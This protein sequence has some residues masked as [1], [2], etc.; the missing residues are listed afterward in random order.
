MSIITKLS[1]VIVFTA[2][3]FTPPQYLTKWIPERDTR[4]V[5]RLA[6][7]FGLAFEFVGLYLTR[8][9]DSLGNH[10]KTELYVAKD[11][12]GG[13]AVGLIIAM[14]LSRYFRKKKGVND[15]A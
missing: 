6:G 9:G 4:W 13:V 12:C 3:A 14:L 1:T 10:F 8:E 15:V 5:V 11:F 2:F 7:L